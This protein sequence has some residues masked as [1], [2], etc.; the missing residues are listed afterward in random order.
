[1]TTLPNIKSLM[2][3]QPHYSPVER[4]V[5]CG[6]MAHNPL[7]HVYKNAADPT[8]INVV[9]RRTGDNQ[10]LC[11]REFICSIT[12]FLVALQTIVRVVQKAA[13]PAQNRRREVGVLVKR[14]GFQTLR[15][16]R[17][18]ASSSNQPAE[19]LSDDRAR[20]DNAAE[21]TTSAE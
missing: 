5:A 21:A 14:T 20:D 10:S 12:S 13:D 16:K 15:E 7:T 19:S 17:M 4:C 1:M 8:T 11:S 9:W 3:F 2:L 18:A 6:N